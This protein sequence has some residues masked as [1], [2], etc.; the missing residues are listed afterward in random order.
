MQRGMWVI[1]VLV[2]HEVMHFLR[3]YVQKT[4][5]T[6]PPR[7]TL[8]IGL[9]YQLLLKVWTLYNSQTDGQV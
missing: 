8:T 6:I 3:R 7:V 2:S 5:F 4:I 1:L 9:I